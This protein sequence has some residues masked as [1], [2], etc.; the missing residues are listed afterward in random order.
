MKDVYY[1]HTLHEAQLLVDRLAERQIVTFVRNSELQGML[2]ELPMTMRP[3]VCV[4]NDADWEQARKIANDFEAASLADPGPDRPCPQCGESSPG[5][6]Q[7][8]WNCR[9]AFELHS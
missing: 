7:V 6:F 1:A 9:H 2:G 8:C 3:V 4:V 5:N